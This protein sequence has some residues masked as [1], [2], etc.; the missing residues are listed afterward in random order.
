M[1]R[2]IRVAV[3]GAGGA[4]QVV[5]LPIL[6]RLPEVEI[7]G[8]ADPELD[9]AKTI[10]E[11]FGVDRV[12]ASIEEL[13]AEGP[14]EA[15]LVCSP[16]YAHEASVMDALERGCHVLCERPLATSVDA[17]LRMI[18]AARKAER[19][20]MVAMNLR[21][22]YDVRA[23][24]HFV[25]NGELG[26]VFYIRSTWMN[27]RARRPR[28]GWRLDPEQAGGGVLMDLGSQAID[29][30]L[31]TL[32]FPRVQ[33]VAARLH[34]SGGVEA[35][36]AVQ[37]ALEAGATATIEVT[38]ELVHER[39]RHVLY[40]LGTRGS[41]RSTPFQVQCTTASG[42]M[43]VTPPLD[44]P[45]TELYSDS[46]RQEWAEFLRHARGEKP[47]EVPEDQVAVARAVEASYRA[48][49]EEREVEV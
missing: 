30:A 14:V 49:A 33:R 11:R 28:R 22:R 17:T 46:Y 35:T 27:R 12:A 48:A 39:D 1:A 6:K 16:N 8:I 41:A 20:L 4:A 3:L 13:A 29:L 15:A 43:D 44:W 19:H 42:I 26:D 45:P 21:F 31:W 18:D 2:G 24:K 38:W 25:A 37:L 5:H 7:A 47:P 23:I 34:G 36:A 9:K 10:A 40:V 32:D